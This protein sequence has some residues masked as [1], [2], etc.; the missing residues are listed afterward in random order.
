MPISRSRKPQ[1][2]VMEYHYDDG[3]VGAYSIT[4]GW[5]I[6]WPAPR[7]AKGLT[8]IVIRR[9]TAKGQ[10]LSQKMMAAARTVTMRKTRRRVRRA[11]SKS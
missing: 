1:R 11:S 5:P 9:E 3:D 6:E 4:D 10:R 8:H 7:A 2:L